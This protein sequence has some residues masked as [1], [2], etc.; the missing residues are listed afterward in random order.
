MESVIMPAMWLKVLREVIILY[1]C[2]AIFPVAVILFVI[3]DDSL[4]AGM[5]M[6]SRGVLFWGASQA[7][8]STAVLIRLIAP[9]LIVQAVRGHRWSQRSLVG[10]KW[11]N[12][13]FSLLLASIAGWAFW[14]AWD[15]FYFMYALEDIPGELLQF[16][17][18]EWSSVLIF[19]TASL[20]CI[21][22]FS[23][24]VDPVGKP[25]RPSPTSHA[26]S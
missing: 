4:S 7:G 11:V 25:P 23:I 20:L 16:L 24:F 5:A 22:C 10:K 17:E 26:D 3:Y 2:L 8:L 15:M 18:L 1:L 12:L 19:L 21:R 13:Y 9:Y 6:L 14:R